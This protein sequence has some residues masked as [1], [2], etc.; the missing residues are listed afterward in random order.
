[1]LP[2]VLVAVL[3]AAAGFLAAI[4]LLLLWV[5]DHAAAAFDRSPDA[6]DPI[7]GPRDRIVIHDGGES[8]IPMPEE[9]R[10]RDEMVAWMTKE[11]PRLTAKEAR[12]AP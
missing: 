1:M 12:G 4:W 6:L 3:A 8:F 2:D 10:T 11:L 5:G 7:M 9:L